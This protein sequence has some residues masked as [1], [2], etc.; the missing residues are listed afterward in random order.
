MRITRCLGTVLAS[1]A[2]LLPGATDGSAQIRASE[3]GTVSQTIDGTVIT[4]DYG[5]PRVRGRTPVYGELIPWGKIWTAGANW[6]TTLD[7]NRDITINGQALAAGKYSVWL[8][9]QQNG[10][11]AIFDPQPRRFHMQPPPEADNQ[12]RFAV[13]PEE[14]SFVETL[15]WSFPDTRATGTTL[16]MAWGDRAVSFDIGVHPSRTLTVPEDLAQRYVGSYRLTQ[17]A[18][19]SAKDVSFEISFDGEHLVA[20]WESSPNPLLANV[21]LVH[22]GEN[23][24]SPV[25]LM[26]GELWDLLVDMTFEF[27][28][29]E[30]Q[31]TGFE[32]RALDDQLWGTATRVN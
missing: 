19:L 10:W 25:E 16:Q 26:D 30:G 6:A 18:P 27:S 20:R 9:V 29:L 17:R 8:H 3:R 2:F 31:A 5:R 28:P 14:V 21:W 7:V 15:T 12:V 24:F 23:I 32:L 22:R 13:Q 4:L 1:G 11:T